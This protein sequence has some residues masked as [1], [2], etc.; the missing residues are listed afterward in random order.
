MQALC[1]AVCRHGDEALGGGSLLPFIEK[2]G[3]DDRMGTDEGTAVALDTLGGIPTGNAH[4]DAALLV[5]CK[6]ERDAAVRVIDETADGQVVA[7]LPVDRQKE[8]THRL[9]QAG[10]VF[11]RRG[12]QKCPRLRNRYLYDFRGAGVDG[13]DIARHHFVALGEI[14]LARGSLHGLEGLRRTDDARG[15]E[16]SSLKHGIGV[17][18]E[19]ETQRHGRSI[20]HVET[21][22]LLSQSAFHVCRKPVFQLCARITAVQ[23]EY[24]SVLEFGDYV[25]LS[26]VA[27]VVACY[28]VGMLHVIR[29]L[30]RLAAETEMGLGD[31]ERLLR[32]IFEISLSVHPGEVADNMDCIF[33]GSHGA[34]TAESPEL[35]AEGAFGRSGVREGRK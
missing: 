27:L 21:R 8:S 5:S 24:A 20:D 25:V 13:R 1:L 30:H 31:S 7:L 16:E 3:T 17:A 11:S 34:V 19:A 9:R 4:R 6:A 26:D 33:V 35:A 29:T 10:K 15:G 2:E 22:M 28:E 18:S 23:Q 12:G 32:I 14:G